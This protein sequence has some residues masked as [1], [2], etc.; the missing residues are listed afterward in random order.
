MQRRSNGYEN[1][2]IALLDILIKFCVHINVDQIQIK[3]LWQRN[4]P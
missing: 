1:T 2:E 4:Y 3:E